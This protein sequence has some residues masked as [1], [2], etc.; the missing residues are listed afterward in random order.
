MNKRLF[1][2]MSAIT[3]LKGFVD[4][5]STHAG[6]TVYTLH[7]VPNKCKTVQIASTM[8]EDEFYVDIDKFKPILHPLSDLTKEIVHK[9]ERFV[10]LRKLLEASGFDLSVMGQVLI[11]EY[12]R[13]FSDIQL[14]GI[15]DVILLGEWH[16]NLM[17]EGEEFIDVNTLDINP[18]K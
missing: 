14:L 5:R 4:G 8:D 7:S 16:F 18:Y 12:E 2:A 13:I 17:G 1:L 6:P 15:S 11:N 3:S 9:G 10:P